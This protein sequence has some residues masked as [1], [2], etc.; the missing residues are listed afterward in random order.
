MTDPSFDPLASSKRFRFP[1][2]RP[3]DAFAG[4]VIERELAR[5]GAGAVFV[6]R[7]Q[8]GKPY[9]LKL[10]LGDMSNPVRRERFRREVTI[11]TSL[12]H[13]GIVRV[14]DHGE[15]AGRS[16][17]VMEL[18]EDALPID[19][20]V[21]ERDV[22]LRQRVQLLMEAAQTVH[23]A[24]KAEIVH[25]DLKPDNV[26]V[27]PSGQVKV[28]DFGIAKQLDRE[29]LTQTGA[30]MGTLHYMAPE[31]V[32]GQN[33]LVSPRTDVYALG[34]LAYQIM[35]GELPIEGGSGLEVM[36]AIVAG[37][38][39]PLEEL[40]PQAPRGMA[41]VI[42]MAMSVD[43]AERYADA[44]ALAKDL[45]AVCTDTETEA[46]GRVPL[47]PRSPRGPA[48]ALVATLLAVLVG[49]YTWSSHRTT[50][51]P[52]L[53]ADAKTLRGEARALLEVRNRFLSDDAAAISDLSR[54]ADQ[55][56][57]AA[58]PGAAHDAISDGL[59]PVRA[60]EGMLALSRNDLQRARE[61]GT[62]GAA[63]Q[64]EVAALRAAL[65]GGAPG[66]DP[67]K[68]S[69]TIEAAIRRGLERPDLYG[70]L[71]TAQG[72]AGVSSERQGNV[73]LDALARVKRARGGPLSLDESCL[74][75][76]ARIAK[77]DLELASE[78][79]TEL[80]DAAPPDLVW[81]VALARAELRL[82]N[83][84]P[85]EALEFLRDLPPDTHRALRVRLR[86]RVWKRLDAALDSVTRGPS[87]TDLEPRLSTLTRL[88][89][90]LWPDAPLAEPILKR[91][92]AAATSLETAA[93]LPQLSAA[94][95]D[96]VPN[97]RQVQFKLAAEAWRGQTTSAQ[98]RLFLP[99]LRRACAL[100]ETR[101][102]RYK[103]H[104]L[105]F[106]T[107]R[108]THR[109]SVM[110]PAERD[111]TLRSVT[112]A[113]RTSDDPD[114]QVEI[115]HSL[116]DFHYDLRDYQPSLRAAEDAIAL[117][118][119]R[120]GSLR[121]RIRA[122]QALARYDDDYVRHVSRH[123]RLAVGTDDAN[124]A[125]RFSWTLHAHDRSADALASLEPHM[126]NDSTWHHRWWVRLSLLQLLANHRQ[127]ALESLRIAKRRWVVSEGGEG[128][129]TL[130]TLIE[131]IERG[132]AGA[133]EWKALRA[134]VQDKG[135][136]PTD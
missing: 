86:N 29:R 69:R 7:G 12:L 117:N 8:D 125:L 5:G 95:S 100:A 134:L 39:L 65:A 4:Y 111:E 121:L 98:D 88:A 114:A 123:S 19:C 96:A 48:I 18:I 128:L 109:D 57:L 14:L 83:D 1:L 116:S 75:A 9:A 32:S 31:Q 61:L 74:W 20:Y 22:S 84:A 6:A 54:R 80:G 73:I 112:I 16:F 52:Q 85:Q 68:A 27:T 2:P 64:P 40:V 45:A 24:H 47:P 76:R 110:P 42:R 90:A 71:A 53:R 78:V 38:V 36:T 33:A 120:L 21:R 34:V 91:I 11:G 119:G 92:V 58:S 43:P 102:D 30:V 99:T 13:A 131:A 129:K 59:A 136:A 94:I 115:L 132:K 97:D 46:S 37:N 66:T 28:V 15:L 93:G 106:K 67:A 44:G 130:K 101:S 51:L 77:G 127:A 108:D 23:T 107:L 133:P 10:F 122:L 3:G 62:R 113:L 26:L 105:L 118:E 60:L 135:P 126:T 72:R 70:W 104:S 49:A 17:L 82:A 50:S 81:D 55:L 124:H 35:S 87:R 41:D 79:L 103:Y 56:L 63:T 25:R 89:T